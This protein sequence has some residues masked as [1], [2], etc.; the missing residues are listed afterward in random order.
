[1]IGII[2]ISDPIA[3]YLTLTI[4]YKGKEKRGGGWGW[5]VVRNL[6]MKGEY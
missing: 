4:I 5:G 2:I 3:K 6:T 1:M